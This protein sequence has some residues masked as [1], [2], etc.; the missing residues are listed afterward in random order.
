MQVNKTYIKKMNEMAK[1]RLPFLFIIDFLG[2]TPL[3]YPFDSIPNSI[4]FSTPGFPDKLN[5]PPKEPLSLKKHPVSLNAYTEKFRQVIQHIEYGNTFLVNLSQATKL[6]INWSLEEIYASSHAPYKLLINNQ[7]VVF[8]PEIFIRTKGLR[9]ET[10]PMKGTIDASIEDAHN[11]I[12]NDKKEEAE[13]YTIVDLMRNDLSGIAINVEVEKFR[14]I[15]KIITHEKE[16]LQVSSMITGELPEN[17]LDNMGEWLFQLL[18]AGSITGA[19]KEKT[20]DI[21][22]EVE[23]YDR[24]YYTGVFGVFDGQNIDSAVMIRYIEKSTDGLI[25]KSGGGITYRS[26]AEKEYQELKDK[27]YVPI[28]GKH[29]H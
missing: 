16:I 9:I 12:L 29:P 3:I 11:E 14:Y 26:D 4:Q 25:F 2:L 19:P 21:L 5:T 13:H 28:T 8:S 1:A 27:V 22:T 24:G 6:E 23:G 15:D 20:V 7:F 17:H 18:P 10:F